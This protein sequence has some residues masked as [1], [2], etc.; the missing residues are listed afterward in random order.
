MDSSK[1]ILLDKFT[2]IDM[3]LIEGQIT[4]QI[5]VRDFCDFEII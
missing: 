2:C 1:F 5:S 3:V 4:S